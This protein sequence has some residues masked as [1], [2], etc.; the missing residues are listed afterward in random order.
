L[1]AYSEDLKCELFTWGPKPQYLIDRYKEYRHDSKGVSYK[2]FLEEVY[3]WYARNKNKDLENEL[4]PLI[5]SS[6]IS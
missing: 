6:I 3:L 1:I 4:F 5:Q 2:E